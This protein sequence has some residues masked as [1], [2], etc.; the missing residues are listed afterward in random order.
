MSR[1][2]DEAVRR[3]T[4]ACGLADAGAVRA[5]L[6]A[7]V[8]VVCDGGG[9]VPAPLAPVHGAGDGAEL[10]AAVLGQ[11]GTELSIESVNGRA[12]LAL[13]RAGRVIAVVTVEV[14]RARIATVWIVLDPAKLSGWHRG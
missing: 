14:V 12:G 1:R 3:L 13:R 2:H 9:V 8:V 11:A 5:A 4:E 10:I 7:D 6:S